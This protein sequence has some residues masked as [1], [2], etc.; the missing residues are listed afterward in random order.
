[1]NAA[2]DP[3]IAAEAGEIAASA[4]AELQELVAI[5]S[6]SGDIAGAERALA[7][8]VRLLPE[9]AVVQRAECSSPDHAPDLIGTVSGT[10]TKKVMLLGHVDTV[11]SHGAHQPLRRDG[12]RLYGTGTV[13][14]KGGDILALGV[15]RM[16][17]RRPETF[18][19]LAVLMV[20]D[21]EWRTHPFRHAGRGGPFSGYDVCLCFEGGQL[22]NDGQEGVVVRRK[23][24]GTLRVTATGRASHSGSAPDHGLNALLALAR[25]AAA[26]AALHDPHGPEQLSVVPTV[27]RSGDAFNVVPAAGELIFDLRAQR[28]A[29]FD[30]VLASVAPEL[31]GVTLDAG[32]E[33]KW[34]GMD[35]TAVTSDLLA[36]ASRRLGRRISG[37]PRGGASDASHFADTIPLTVDGLGPRGGG[38]HTPGEFVLEPTLRERAE[39]ALALAHE[40]LSDQPGG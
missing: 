25:T 13:D 5:S 31:D 38:A 22:D 36:R 6:P 21:E 2:R 28:L 32:M 8:C 35:S 16:L 7:V 12:D 19:E 26:V 4:P 33:R 10:G 29:A 30:E 23:A 27:M 14:M 17:A 1:M 37:V 34:P 15:A 40:V 11:V 18:A 20:T 39:V 3:L 9:G 24:A